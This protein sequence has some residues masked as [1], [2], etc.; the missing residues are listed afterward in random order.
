MN[1]EKKYILDACC[2]SRMFWFNPKH[3]NVLYVD[4]R[5]VEDKTIYKSEDGKIERKLTVDPDIIA[6]F[7][8]LPFEDNQFYHIVFDPPHLFQIGENSWMAQKYGKLPSDWKTLIHDGFNE[9]WRVLK[10]FGTLIFKWNETQ[11]PTKE[12]IK[13]IGR[14]PLYGHK[15]GKMSKTHWMAFMKLPEET[16]LKE[17]KHD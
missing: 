2:A 10:P 5:I 13:T 11:I 14:E 8:N 17:E 1:L 16:I 9:C 12:V 6:D 15:S 3:E 4:K 7:C